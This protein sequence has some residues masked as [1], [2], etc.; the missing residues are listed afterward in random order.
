MPAA[1]TAGPFTLDEI[2]QACG[3]RIDGDGSVLIRQV[4]TL[5]HAGTGEIAFLANPRYRSQLAQTRAAAVVLGAADAASTA[6]P[7]LVADQPYVA[8][9]RVAHLLNPVA[10]VTGGVA[11]SA[12]IEAGAVV[13]ASAAI[14]AGA[15]IGAAAQIGDG[16][17]IHTGAIVGA[18]CTVGARTVIHPHAVLYPDTVIGIEGVIHAGAVVGADGFGMAETGAGWLKIPQ[19]GRVV[20]GDRVGI[21]AN[22][23]IDRGALDDT[24]IGDDA[25]LDNQI[26]IGHNVQIGARTAIAGCVGIAGSVHIGSDCKIGGAAM[27]SGHIA[28]GDRVTIAGGTVVAKSL[29]AAGVYAGVYPLDTMDRW[30]R[31]AVRVRRLDE[32]AARLEVVEKKLQGKA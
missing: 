11:P 32:L 26:Q 19:I 6:I 7:R 18:R 24:V 31:T 16:C 27:I 8:Y 5:E 25:K 10:V 4:N 14:G 3:G 23:T 15:F 17:V 30:R 9:A 28:I 20:I 29:A 12:T 13:A 22:T 21:G 1:P 2:A